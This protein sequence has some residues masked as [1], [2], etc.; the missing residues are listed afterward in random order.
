MSMAGVL[1]LTSS[2]ERNLT[3]SASVPIGTQI[4]C[5]PPSLSPVPR[6]NHLDSPLL[7]NSSKGSNVISLT[8]PCSRMRNNGMHG[9]E[10]LSLLPEHMVVKRSLTQSIALLHLIPRLCLLRSKSSCT[11]CLKPSLR[12]IWA[13]T[14]FASTRRSLMLKLST[15]SLHSMRPH[16]LRQPLMLLAS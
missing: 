13:S 15:R 5:S 6:V 3:P 4:T 8:T 9:N 12:L 2:P 7:M 1:I 14:L 16:Q 11:L 10:L